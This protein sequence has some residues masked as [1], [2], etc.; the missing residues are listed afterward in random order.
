MGAKAD[1]GGVGV[2]ARIGLR[3]AVHPPTRLH[4][5][6]QFLMQHRGSV[7]H[8]VFADADSV[9]NLRSRSGDSLFIGMVDPSAAASRARVESTSHSPP[10]LKSDHPL[11]IVSSSLLST[12]SHSRSASTRT[13]Q[14]V[15]DYEQQ[16]HQNQY[17]DQHGHNNQEPLSGRRI[18]LLS[19]ALA[20]GPHIATPT[21]LGFDQ[22]SPLA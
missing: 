10:C 15:H 6:G 3:L 12:R 19:F 9:H 11:G 16:P 7:L 14:F 1:H 18:V 5:G 20:C 4:E 13:S 21:T 22:H 2:E 8:A 17:H